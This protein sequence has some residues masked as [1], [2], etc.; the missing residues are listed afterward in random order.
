MPYSTSQLAKGIADKLYSR[1]IQMDLV[2]PAD[3]IFIFFYYQYQGYGESPDAGDEFS[4]WFKDSKNFWHKVWSVQVDS[5]SD[6]TKFV[7]VK[8][9]LGRL[10][11]SDSTTY[12]F[13][14]F[15]FRFQNFARLSG[16]F[17]SW[18]LDYVYVN[19][20]KLQYAPVYADCPDRAI[21]NPL[22]TIFKQYQSMPVK[23]F[24][25]KLDTVLVSQQ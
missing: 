12:F 13:N 15:Q 8:I 1:P 21:T 6:P 7:P 16:P 25:T 22:S 3:S 17:D 4:L 24:L 5:A 2:T 9:S 11:A 23:H 14:N 10:K 19:N 18:N 20:G